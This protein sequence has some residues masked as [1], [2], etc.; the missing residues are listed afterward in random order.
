MIWSQLVFC[1]RFLAFFVSLDKD[2]RIL[3]FGIWTPKG[4]RQGP[5]RRNLRLGRNKSTV[6]CVQFNVQEAWEIF[7]KFSHTFVSKVCFWKRLKSLLDRVLLANSYDEYNKFSIE[8]KL[9]LGSFSR[10]NLV[11]YGVHCW[12][13]GY[14]SKTEEIFL[15]FLEH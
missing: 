2:W 14:R 15:E 6:L 11:S 9:F 10:F 4:A 3:C 1:F 8:A 7:W 13:G 12:I 5:K